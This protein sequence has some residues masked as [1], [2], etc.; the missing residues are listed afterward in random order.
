MKPATRR[1]VLGL[2]IVLA[3]AAVFG[4]CKDRCRSCDMTGPEPVPACAFVITPTAQHFPS[5]GGGGNIVVTTTPGCA[6]NATSNSAWIVVDS[7]GGG[8]VAYTVRQNTGDARTGTLTVSGQTVTVTQ[9]G[10]P[11][12]PPKPPQPSPPQPTPEPPQPT[13]PPTPPPSCQYAVQASPQQFTY[14][15]GNGGFSVSASRSDCGWTAISNVAWIAITG[16]SPGSGNGSVSYLVAG[17]GGGA[18]TGTISVAGKTVTV[19]QSAK[20]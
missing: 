13:P 19:S 18:R 3:A 5:Q 8:T 14:E 7:A 1:P 4:S 16:G 12:A 15:G 17:N 9:D 6:W 20:P 2:F 10:A 11:S